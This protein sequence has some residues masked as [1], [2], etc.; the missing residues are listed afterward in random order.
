VWWVAVKILNQQLENL[1]GEDHSG[2]IDVEWRII[3][4]G[5]RV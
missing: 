5:F 1:Y 3:L 2:D 4:S